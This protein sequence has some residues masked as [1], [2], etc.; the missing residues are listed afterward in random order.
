[1]HASARFKNHGSHHVHQPGSQ[2]GKK[3]AEY[4]ALQLVTVP[5]P[6]LLG[7]SQKVLWYY[8]N[9]DDLLPAIQ[10]LAALVKFY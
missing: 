9:V 6:V 10:L 3:A 5:R 8:G 1:M 4:T 7:I 2:A